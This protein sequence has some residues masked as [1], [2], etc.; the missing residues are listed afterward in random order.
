M[1][2][3][4]GA[5]SRLPRG[6]DAP[7]SSLLQSWARQ[8]WQLRILRGFLGGTFVIAGVQKLADPNFLHS[9]SPDYIG[10]QL[11]AFAHG[12]PIGPFLSI[13]AHFALLTGI[14]VALIEMA[15][16]LGTLLGVAPM[17]FAAL[18]LGLNL[19]LFLSAT[20]HVHPYFLGSD[21]IYAVAWGAYLVG[22]VDAKRRAV[23]AA[24][25]VGSRRARARQMEELGRRE[26]LRGA[27]VG[28]GS[29]MLGSVA[30]ALEGR[31][32]AVADPPVPSSAPSTS[33]TPTITKSTHHAKPTTPP[34]GTSIASLDN[35]PIG[36]AVNFDDPAQGP[37]VLV[38]LAQDQV[39][40]YSRVCTHAG[41]LVD[42]DRS[43][44]L[45]LCPCHGAEFDP[46]QDGQPVA[47]PAF[48]PLPSINVTIDQGEVIAGS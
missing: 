21:S 24:Q 22:L 13:A 42:Y 20:W 15:V 48:S 46:S 35:L 25:S 34:P 29:L 7:T 18:G 6:A 17:T 41:C 47:G 16:G 9:G 28:L 27:L 12:S 26:F 36:S 8:S 37:S 19:V 44:K 43:S 40:A 30:F 11:K 23:R 14:A 2:V 38:R 32:R 4:L 45:L 5:M 1:A 31:E 3:R 10:E 33:P 39:A